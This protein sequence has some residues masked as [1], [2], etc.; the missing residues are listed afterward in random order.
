MNIGKILGNV[1]GVIGSAFTGN[2]LGF[3]G[4]ALDL[5]NNVSGKSPQDN[6]IKAQQAE[7]E[8]N[9]QFNSE[10]AKL[11]Y[12]RQI[13]F[14]KM[15]QDYNTPA[16]LMRRYKDA[17]LNPDLVYGQISPTNPSASS[18]VASSSGSVGSD[19]SN[20]RT[21]GDIAS[22]ALQMQRE[23]AEIDNIKAD[24]ANKN[25]NTA[26]TLTYNQFQEKLLQGQ[27]DLNNMNLMLGDWTAKLN[28]AEQKRLFQE[29][30]NLEKSYDVLS[31]EIDKLRASVA[32]IDAD[33]ALKKL[34]A[35]F[36]TPRFKAEMEE[37]ASR[38]NKN[39]ADANLS[40]AQASEIT[41]LLTYKML[42][43]ESQTASNWQSVQNGIVHIGTEKG[44]QANLAIQGET[45][46]W[47]LTMNK[48]FGTAERAVGLATDIQSYLMSPVQ[49]I[50][51]LISLGK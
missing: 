24:T 48:T 45:M 35:H 4:S 8:R 1:G 42:N 6:S 34:E 51:K 15:Q 2:P 26:G 39:Y 21:L 38:I 41:Q 23:K 28:D 37:V 18:P 5:I 16:A 9:R 47:D 7:N 31:A 13:A 20:K 27:I 49:N 33:T 14:W 30:K 19:L 46:D 32:N 43:L 50:V 17:G 29:T 3:A 25:A 44:I 40:A 36:A 10:Q 11:A 22:M 12:D